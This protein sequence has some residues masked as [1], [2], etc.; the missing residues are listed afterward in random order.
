MHTLTL[1]ARGGDWM[2]GSTRCQIKRNTPLPLRF[3]PHF[4][5]R[6]EM[7]PAKTTTFSP[8]FAKMRENA[9]FRATIWGQSASNRGESPEILHFMQH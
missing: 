9:V 2:R 3:R 8:F 7:N 4:R 6:L 1:D 5:G